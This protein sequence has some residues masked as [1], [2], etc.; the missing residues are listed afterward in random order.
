MGKKG[1]LAAQAWGMPTFEG[2]MVRKD[3]SGER[4]RSGQ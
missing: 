4:R 3:V 1:G 2:S